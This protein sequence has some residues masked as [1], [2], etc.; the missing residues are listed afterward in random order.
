MAWKHSQHKYK[1]KPVNCP[2]DGYFAST[3][4]YKDWQ[5]LKMLERTGNISNLK[6]QVKFPLNGAAGEKVCDYIADAT[7]VEDGKQVAWDT[8]GMIT[9]VY[10]LKKKLFCQQY[11][12][13]EHRE[14]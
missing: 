2:I 4:E 12:D 5:T 10:R 14:S 11:P 1:A 13:W 7:F 6:R 8:K 9:D 3:K